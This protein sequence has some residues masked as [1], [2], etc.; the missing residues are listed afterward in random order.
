M[1]FFVEKRTDEPS[2][3]TIVFQNEQ[4]NIEKFEFAT[5][6]DLYNYLKARGV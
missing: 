2:S 1:A 3:V 4:G 6:A 5:E